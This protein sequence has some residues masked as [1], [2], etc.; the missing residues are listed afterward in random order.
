MIAIPPIDCT[1]AG[2]LV[3]TTATNLAAYAAGTTYAADATV[4]YTNRNWV[5][6][7]AS[8]VGHTPGTDTLW[9]VD[10]GPVN[11]L[12]MFDSSVQT[13]TTATDDLTITL[14]VGRTTAVGLMGLVG[15][16]VTL[17]VR[18]GLGGTVIATYTQTLRTTD[19]SYYSFCFEDF[20]QVADAAWTGLPGSVAGHITISI[21][22]V[23]TVSCGLCVVG[24][25]F[26]IGRATYGF[27]MPIEDRG[28]SYL[29]ALNNPVTVERGYSR[30]ASGTVINTRNNY[31]R[32][33]QFF[34]DNVNTPCLFIAAP[35]S[36][37]L[38][39][40]T[41]FGK[42]SRVVP[43]ISGYDEITTSLDIA[44]YR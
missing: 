25:Q 38:V 28:R 5:S 7:Q 22:G 23:G 4:S 30:E 20:T 21:T 34:A 2:V 32:L 24:K 35:G 40:A 10:D 37:D 39:S 16:S 26:D 15:Q 44:G 33:L 9:W 8:N 17:T 27:S 12:A 3:S 1:A 36:T 42:I 43:V 31:N 6:V 13:A 41:T 11:T 18:D 29:D 14:N 19:G